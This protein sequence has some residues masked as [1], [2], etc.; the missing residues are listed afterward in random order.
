MFTVPIGDP[1]DACD[2]NDSSL[3]GGID[4]DGDGELDEACLE[5]EQFDPD[6][7]YLVDLDPPILPNGNN[8]LASGS[9]VLT[10]D[11]PKGGQ[12]PPAVGDDEITDSLIVLVNALEDSDDI[13]KKLARDSRDFLN[14]AKAE[15]I[16]DGDSDPEGCAAF[17][18]F[19]AL[20][21]NAA[22][23]K[24]SQAAKN[25]ISPAIDTAQGAAPTGHVCADTLAPATIPV[26]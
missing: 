7:N 9:I 8:L 26:V 13:Q 19:E 23:N 3:A 6:S 10:K 24:V 12:S 21:D 14:T 5:G 22:L 16:A 17:D 20:I 15:F 1:V 25:A 4:L 2:I 11:N 18:Q